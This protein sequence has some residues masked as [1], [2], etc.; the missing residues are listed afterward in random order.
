[1]R[2]WLAFLVLP[3]GLFGCSVDA[4]DLSL[5]A[6][7]TEPS[8]Q[9]TNSAFSGINGSFKLDLALGSE[10]N[11]STR[12]S[13]GNFELQ[14]EAGESLV[15]LGD[16]SPEPMFPIDLNKGESKTVVFTIT[17]ISV[18]RDAVC[19]GNVRIVGSVMDTLKN[20]TEPVQSGLFKPDCSD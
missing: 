7:I 16:A 1:M 11:G 4:S 13:S 14:N 9:V 5:T 19:A 15:E 17:G 10:A 6:R 18:D 3:V 12:V 20:G 2:S 8:I